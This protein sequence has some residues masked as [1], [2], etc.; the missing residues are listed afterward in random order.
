M[1]CL[2]TGVH[3]PAGS[4]FQ[5]LS[6]LNVALEEYKVRALNTLAC[7]CYKDPDTRVLL[8]TEILFILTRLAVFN[9]DSEWTC[10]KIDAGSK[11]L[12]Y[13]VETLTSHM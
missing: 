7:E 12:K 13:Y 8:S 2:D 9:R 1:M 3:L 5:L 11:Q 6:C 4:S 10:L